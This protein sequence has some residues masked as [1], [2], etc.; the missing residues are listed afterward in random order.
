MIFHPERTW[1]HITSQ[2]FTCHQHGLLGWGRSMRRQS[3]ALETNQPRA[4]SQMRQLQGVDAADTLH[5]HMWPF[6]L[7][8][9]AAFKCLGY[10]AFRAKTMLPTTVRSSGISFAKFLDMTECGMTSV[11]ELRHCQHG[12]HLDNS[13][14]QRNQ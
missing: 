10:I 8:Y 2:R 14:L 13:I 3:R 11:H 4:P 12:L 9:S 5:V 6:S 7:Q 1:A